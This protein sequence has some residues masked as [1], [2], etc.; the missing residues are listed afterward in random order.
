MKALDL[1]LS[2]LKDNF[3]AVARARATYEKETDALVERIRDLEAKRDRLIR[4]PI[5]R[6]DLLPV[7]D[8]AISEARQAWLE[9]LGEKLQKLGANHLGGEPRVP[10]RAIAGLDVLGEDSIGAF[11]N[12]YG[13]KT[14]PYRMGRILFALL[15][16]QIREALHSAPY[17]QEEGLPIA[18]RRRKVDGL[19]QEID[20]LKRKVKQLQDDAAAA[21]LDV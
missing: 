17:Y 20:T 11:M 10:R 16:D 13:E 14:A 9:E 4:A 1:M 8:H 19:N 3:D 7:L 12:T 15:G 2:K 21:G 5:P 18:E 6:S